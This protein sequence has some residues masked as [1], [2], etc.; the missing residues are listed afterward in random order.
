MFTENFLDSHCS[1]RKTIWNLTRSEHRRKLT[2]KR[3]LVS[4][5]EAL[6]P[7]RTSL[8]LGKNVNEK[9]GCSR[10]SHWPNNKVVDA[11][12][13]HLGMKMHETGQMAKG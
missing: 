6:W 10:M 2:H 1:R 9:H 5:T 13:N 12:L 4:E 7:H 3:Y 8:W 11:A